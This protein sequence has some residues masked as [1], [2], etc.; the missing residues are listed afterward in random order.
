MTNH[1]KP[2]P[3]ALASNFDLGG[4]THTAAAS[5]FFVLLVSISLALRL[6]T[7]YHEIF[8]LIFYEH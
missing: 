6:T 7:I 4:M 5:N 8:G 2:M 3:T 1:E